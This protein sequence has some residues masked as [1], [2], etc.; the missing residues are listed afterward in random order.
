M[1]ATTV[2]WFYFFKQSGYGGEYTVNGVMP[3]AY[4]WLAGAVAMIV[5]SLVT[6]PPSKQTIAKFFPS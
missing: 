4:C 6:K 3:V 2:T 5:V 1:I